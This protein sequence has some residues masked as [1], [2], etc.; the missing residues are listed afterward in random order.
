MNSTDGARGNEL[1]QLRARLAGQESL[2]GAIPARFAIPQQAPTYWHI[3]LAAH[4][5][6]VGNPAQQDGT[7]W[8]KSRANT[9]LAA[10]WTGLVV[11]VPTP[12]TF[13][14]QTAGLIRALNG[15]TPGAI[16]YVDAATAG[17]VT[18][19]APEHMMPVY[20][21][22]TAKTAILLSPRACVTVSNADPGSTA[23]NDG[24]M[25]YKY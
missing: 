6:A 24:D 25:W 13:V 5:F 3:R 4:G 14:I 2:T 19:T 9:P 15:L 1:Q 17:A 10:A 8:V 7:T 21:A 22:L 20:R 12:A 11:A 18:T 23:A 16:Y